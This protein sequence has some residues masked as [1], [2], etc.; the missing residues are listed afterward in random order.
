MTQ[1]LEKLSAQ[2]AW[3]LTHIKRQSALMQRVMVSI[4]QLN[5]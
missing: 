3:L 4:A 2:Q 1:E 5:A